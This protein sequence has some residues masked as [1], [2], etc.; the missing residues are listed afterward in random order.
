[1]LQTDREGKQTHSKYQKKI[2]LVQAHFVDNSYT[3]NQFKTKNRLYNIYITV[4]YTF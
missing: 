4:A 1:M 3:N 2:T